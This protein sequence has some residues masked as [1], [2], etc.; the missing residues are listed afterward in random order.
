MNYP[1]INTFQNVPESTTALSFKLVQDSI[2]TIYKGDEVF[3]RNNIS[4]EELEE[5]VNN[6]TQAQFTKIQTFFDTM[7]RVRHNIKYQNPKTGKEFEM[8]LT[9]TSDFF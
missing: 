2:Q 3:D 4:D 9:G 1:T 5:F 7:P 6:M 8:N